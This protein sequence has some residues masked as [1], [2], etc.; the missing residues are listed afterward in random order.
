[1]DWCLASWA[2]KKSSPWLELSSLASQVPC[3][4]Q[5]LCRIF[6]NLSLFTPALFRAGEN[7]DVEEEGWHHT[8]VISLL[9]QAGF[10]TGVSY[11]QPSIRLSCSRSGRDPLT[12]APPYFYFLQLLMYYC[13]I[14]AMTHLR[15]W[16]KMLHAKMIIISFLFPMTF[17]ALVNMNSHDFHSASYVSNFTALPFCHLKTSSQINLIAVS[18][19]R[20]PVLNV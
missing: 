17:A 6:P 8:S 14:L 11:T 15:F 12:H 1:M 13:I 9:I 5:L 16:Q 2:Y 18:Q 7:E 20:V 10:L 3:S 19:S 4:R